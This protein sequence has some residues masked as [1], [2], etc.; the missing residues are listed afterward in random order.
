MKQN[1]L[2]LYLKQKSYCSLQWYWLHYFVLQC[3]EMKLIHHQQQG[4]Q[5]QHPPQQPR[6]RRPLGTGSVT[7]TV[8]PTTTMIG[9]TFTKR[10]RRMILIGHWSQERHLPTT[11]GRHGL[12]MEDIT[13]TL[14][15]A[16]PENT[17]TRQCK[18]DL[19]C[20]KLY[21]VSRNM[22]FYLCQ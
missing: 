4:N 1:K 3:L 12:L 22:L 15:Q 14:R 17:E 16:V 7:L 6:Q 9:A 11:Q 21:F 20:F 10:W 19:S 8:T 5:P 18:E 2:L 13:S